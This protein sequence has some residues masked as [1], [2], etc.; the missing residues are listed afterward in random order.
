M[1]EHLM[2]LPCSASSSEARTEPQL[3]LLRL[4]RAAYNVTVSA[5]AGLPC[6]CLSEEIQL[7]PIHALLLETCGAA[8][9]VSLL[10]STTGTACTV[11]MALLI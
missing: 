1:V 3:L 8:A 6:S 10:P 4:S 9:P 11:V 2:V 5:P 7:R